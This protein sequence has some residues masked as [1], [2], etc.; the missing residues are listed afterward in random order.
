MPAG[1]PL[2]R[3]ILPDTDAAALARLGA[4]VP[5]LRATPLGLEIPLGD[6]GAEEA[7]ALCLRCG[8]TCRGTS[9]IE[10]IRGG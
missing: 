7:L 10:P 2:L 9:V 6:L 4:L 3:L 1:A 8:V 5:G